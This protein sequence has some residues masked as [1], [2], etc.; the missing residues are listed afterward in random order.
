MAQPWNREA[1]YSE[2]WAEPVTA[3]AKRYGV[4][5][6]AIAKVCM[7]V[8]V[9]LPGRGY[10]AKKAH[11]YSVRQVAL[12]TMK[13]VPVLWQPEPKP[14]QEKAPLDPELIDQRMTREEFAPC[15]ADLKRSAPLEAA[16]KAMHEKRREQHF[17]N[18]QLAFRSDALDLRVSNACLERAIHMVG[19]IMNIGPRIDASVE[20]KKPEHPW[21]KTVTVFTHAG[22]EVAFCLREKLRM[23]KRPASASS[24]LGP[25]HSLEPTGVL[26]FEIFAP[27]GSTKR[28]WQDR[29]QSKIEEQIP[30]IVA[31]LMKASILNRRRVEEW[32]RQALLAR[33]REIE[34]QELAS[35]I[36]E[37]KERVN[38]LLT[39]AQNWK[40]AKT[41][42]EYLPEL[43]K[44]KSDDKTE[45][46]TEYLN[47]TKEQPDRVDPLTRS[48]PSILDQR[49]KVAHLPQTRRP[50]P[51]FGY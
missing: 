17:N 37:E 2:V 40:L 13:Q 32:R 3:V 34:L 51:N 38:K 9:P 45:A 6:N 15:T 12:P 8:K 29:P 1:L 27:T 5:G 44:S 22:N 26:A 24:D 50:G 47:W 21:D 16:R 23:V 36:S 4:S 33:Q 28:L 25:S 7:K 20:T 41:I 35:R 11:G 49:N 39:D 18:S 31:A 48:P 30:E 10:W 46:T 14:A 42:R 19:V 43:A